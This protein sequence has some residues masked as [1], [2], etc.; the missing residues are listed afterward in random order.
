MEIAI[1][2]RGK[3]LDYLF[4]LAWIIYIISVILDVSVFTLNNSFA[5][6]TNKII[7]YMVYGICLAKILFSSYKKTDFLYL[8]IF[9]FVCALSFVMSRNKTM[10]FYSIIMLAS[11]GAL[12]DKTIKITAITQGVLLFSIIILSQTGLL[13]D[14]IFDKGTRERHGLGFMWTTTGPIVFFYFILSYVYLNRRRLKWSR[15]ILLECVNYWLYKK[16]NTRLVF[17]LSSLFLFFILIEIFNKKRFRFLSHFKTVYLAYP[18]LMWIFVLVI[19]KM[20]N[21]SIS[22]WAKINTMLT[23]RLTLSQDAIEHYG[24]NLL[25][26]NV[27]WKGFSISH[28]A[29]TA[30]EYNYVDSS[31]LQM[32]INYGVILMIAVLFVFSYAIYKHIKVNDYYTVVIYIFILTLA[33]TEPQLMN[34]AF[35]P[36]SLLAFGIVAKDIK[37]GKHIHKYKRKWRLG[38]GEIKQTI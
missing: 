37:A 8:L 31:Y 9:I 27:E 18:F 38:T 7:R 29:Y 13:L 21:R 36:F 20:Y 16:T 30:G 4:F 3:R 22:S 23:G 12:N 10:V 1:R 32:T 33:L 17:A 6:M 2:S 15:I 34:F 35:N 19:C 26:N 24:I 11:Y 28:A 14:Y 25:G 5:S